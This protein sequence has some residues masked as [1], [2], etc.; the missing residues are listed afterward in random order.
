MGQA[1]CFVVRCI[2]IALARGAGLGVVRRP[3]RGAGAPQVPMRDGKSGAD[4]LE[5]GWT[6]LEVLGG[7]FRRRAPELARRGQRACHGRCECGLR[8]IAASAREH[9]HDFVRRFPPKRGKPVQ[10]GRGGVERAGRR[11][12][13]IHFVRDPLFFWNPGGSSCQ[14]SGT[15]ASATLSADSLD[16]ITTSIC[17][18]SP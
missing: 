10:P 16:S 14:G 7:V 18:E 2:M 15:S 3:R 6:A 17:F 1:W 13:R 9:A 8:V 11:R 12:A 4:G 5:R